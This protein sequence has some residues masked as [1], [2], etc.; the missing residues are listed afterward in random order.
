MD[1]YIVRARYEDGQQKAE[2]G[3]LE[4]ESG[5]LSKIISTLEQKSIFA[6]PSESEVRTIRKEIERNHIQII[7]LYLQERRRAPKW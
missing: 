7:K 5:W 6:M 4:E 1:A 3:D 2:R